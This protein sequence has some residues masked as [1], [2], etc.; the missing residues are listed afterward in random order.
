MCQDNT[1]RMHPGHGNMGMHHG[2]G[3]MGMH[4]GQGGMG[5]H[6]G[7]GRMSLH[8]EQ[9]GMG[10]HQGQ[11]GCGCHG[12]FNRHLH[13]KQEKIETLGKYQQQL[14]LELQAVKEQIEFLK[15]K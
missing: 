14:E 11:C 1:I 15:G 2:Q 7:H 4:H 5:M 9:S 6:H 10:M 8:H 3:G 12:E 13:T